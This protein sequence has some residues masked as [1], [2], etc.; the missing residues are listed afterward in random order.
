MYAVSFRIPFTVLGLRQYVN[1]SAYVS[2][3][4]LEP[5]TRIKVSDKPF[6]GQRLEAEVIGSQRT[7]R[8]PRDFKW[9]I[10]Q[11]T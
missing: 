6:I 9:K 5:G 4:P 11:N 2:S 10:V 8:T 1:G 7:S 3:G